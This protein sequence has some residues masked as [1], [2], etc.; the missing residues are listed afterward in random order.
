MNNIANKVSLGT[1]VVG[2]L[3]ATLIFAAPS[4]AQTIKGCYTHTKA[5]SVTVIKDATVTP[6]TTKAVCAD[7][8]SV[9]E[10]SVRGPQ[11]PAGTNGTNGTN[12][13]NGADGKDG[14]AGAAGAQGPQGLK[15]ETGATGAAGAAGPQ[16]PQGLKG[17]TGATGAAGAAGA[18][19]PAGPAGATGAAGPKGDTGA[20][21]AVGPQGPQ[22]AVGPIGPQGPSGLSGWARR[23]GAPQTVAIGTTRNIIASCLSDERAI[24]GG[25]MNTDSKG[26]S[27][28]VLGSY[29]NAAGTAWEVQ[30]H[31]PSNSTTSFSVVGY[32]VCAKVA[33]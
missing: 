10:W 11:G 17:E 9:L 25:Y 4:A 8:E 27:N 20:A 24:G 3:A 19:G 1:T 15:G 13:S 14:A 29:P 18:Q 32:A 21:G 2:A 31:S 5:G 22:G 30:I 6:N 7:G 16:G 28:T 23:E 26:T 12:G 33:A